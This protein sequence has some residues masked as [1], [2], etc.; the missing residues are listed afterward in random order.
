MHALDQVV[1][2]KHLLSHPFYQRWMQGTLSKSELQTYVKNYQPHVEAFPR[3]VSAVHA[4]CESVQTRKALLDNLIEEEHGSENHPELW[5]RFGEAL[6]LSRENIVSCA[7]LPQAKVLMDTFLALTQKSFASGLGALYAYESQVPDV[8]K[9]KIEGLQKHYG[10]DQPRG[11]AFF[12]VH[13]QADE[14][15]AQSEKDA[16]D[17]LTDAQKKEA[18]EAASIACDT[19]W[20]F[21]S[22][23]DEAHGITSTM[24]C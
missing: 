17:Q 20:N 22:A 4:Q 9:Q 8:A 15:H 5:L 1:Q 23:I 14:Y 13:L 18:I 16:F 7:K 11:L 19:L 2:Q 21:L 6:D 12:E 10:I 24:H 3:Y